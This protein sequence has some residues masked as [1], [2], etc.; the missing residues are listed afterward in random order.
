MRNLRKSRWDIDYEDDDVL[1]SAQDEDEDEEDE[2]ISSRFSLADEDD[3]EETPRHRRFRSRFYDEDDD[4]DDE[5]EVPSRSRYMKD[6][7]DEDDEEDDEEVYY[8]RSRSIHAATAAAIAG[9]KKKPRKKRN[10]D[11]ASGSGRMAPTHD[12]KKTARMLGKLRKTNK[13]LYEMFFGYEDVINQSLADLAP[14]VNHYN[15]K[16][17]RNWNLRRAS[18]RK[19]WETV[20]DSLDETLGLLDEAWSDL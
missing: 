17:L 12:P 15:K 4:E 13:E 2:V 9:R 10:E 11:R 16:N 5:D 6:D 3:D 14:L 18:I 20:K 1:L 8:P 19:T 7:D